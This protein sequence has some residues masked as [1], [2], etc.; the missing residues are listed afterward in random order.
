MKPSLKPSLI[1]HG[2][3]W[4][5]PDDGVPEC[6]AGCERAL[7]AGWA[8]LARGGLA[9]DA[10]EAAIRILEDCPVF[11]AGTGSHLNRDGH[12]EL[13][14]IIMDGATLNAGAVAAVTGIRNPIQLAR[15][16]LENGE[17]MMLVGDGARQ[18]AQEQGLPLCDPTELIVDRERIAWEHWRGRP[19]APLS[20]FITDQAMGTVGAVALDARGGLVAGTS[21]GGTLCKHPG[22]VGDSPLIGCGCYADRDAGAASCTGLGEAV[23][24]VVLAK[25]AVERLRTGEHPG[26]TAEVCSRHLRDRGRGN[27]GLILLGADG[28][29]A[30][31]FT[32]SRMA[33]GYVAPDGSFVIGPTM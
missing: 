10:V 9:I 3:A 1:V 15:R 33:Y 5:I 32:T 16:V 20:D 11:D 25:T 22:R 6:R 26:V 30:V 2:G 19:D 7:E 8:I 21:T 31:A 27:G 13:D 23:M 29:P 18:F 24:R 17:Q 12:I 14:A 28:T 4:N